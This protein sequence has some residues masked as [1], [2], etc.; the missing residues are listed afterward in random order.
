MKC[1]E[2]KGLIKNQHVERTEIYR[3]NEVNKKKH[4]TKHCEININKF[5]RIERKL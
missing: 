2:N 1:E 3:K 5:M 4:K